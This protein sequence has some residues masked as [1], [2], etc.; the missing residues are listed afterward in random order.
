M[1]E[2]SDALR[3]AAAVGESP[4]EGRALS[5]YALRRSPH[6]SSGHERLILLGTGGGSNPKSTRSGFSN[7]I[8]VGDAAYIIDCGEGANTQAWRS[9]ISMHLH[10][11]P[12]GGSTIQSM[13]ITHLHSDHVIDYANFLMGFWPVDPIDVYGPAPAG[14]PIPTYPPGRSFSPIFPDNPTPGLASM[15]EHLFRAFAYNVNARMADEE[16][17][18]VTDKVRTHEIGVA[19]SGYVPDLDLGVVA[20]AASPATAA[21][22]MDPVVIRSG[23]A[24]GVTVSAVLVQH[25]PVF[26]AIGYRFDT[27]S[28]SVAFSG[29]TGPCENVVRLA[30]GA[31]IL[32]HEVIDVDF[33][34]R[35]VAKMPNRDAIVAHLA[36]SHTSPEDAARIAQ[37]AGVKK[38]VLSHLV[39]GDD[40]PGEEWE[41]RARPYFDGEVICGVDLD[42]FAIGT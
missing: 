42:Q 1:C 40:I 4:A 33:V 26:P 3:S 18:D 20:S 25:A 17:A 15:T 30:R 27:P 9:G 13:Y 11:R 14:L 10:R 41:A 38:L 23:D 35:R 2:A 36:S 7:A 6:Q 12:P 29:D 24:N 31:D 37:R 32:V 34:A 28:G 16:R 19:R 5:E 8:V 21:P 39:P 22:D